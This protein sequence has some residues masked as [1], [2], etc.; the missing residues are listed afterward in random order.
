MERWMLMKLFI[1]YI[2]DPTTPYPPLIHGLQMVA[3]SLTHLTLFGCHGL[4][5]RDILETCPNLEYLTT[6]HRDPIMPL[7]TSSIYPKMK[8]LVL[9]QRL[10]RPLKHETVISIISRFPSLRVVEIKPMAESSVLP[11]LHKYCPHLLAVYFG[12][13]T[14][15][16]G[17]IA[18]VVYPN[19]K[20]IESVY[21][22]GPN[23]Y[24]QH[25]LIQFLHS[26]RDTLTLLQFNGDIEINDN[27]PWS[28]LNGH[29]LPPS[30]Q[31]PDYNSPSFPRLI[32]FHFTNLNPS[33]TSV[34]MVQ[35]ILSNAHNLSAI[36]IHD[37]YFRPEIAKA[38]IKLKHLRKVHIDVVSNEDDDGVHQFLKH[39]IALGDR[40]TLKYVMVE[41]SHID[42][43]AKPWI[44]LLSRL[45]RLKNLELLAQAISENCIPFMA[46]IGQGCPVLE[47]LTLGVDGADLADGLLVPLRNHPNIKWLRIGAADSLSVEDLV[48]LCTFRDLT[49]L[50][51][52]FNAADDVL[53]MLNK[54]IPNVEIDP[55][56]DDDE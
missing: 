55:Y 22:K 4:Q 6:R 3:D 15:H 51:L 8:H 34:P 31:P 53:E 1:Y 35:W 44:P 52:S 41:T 37:I 21:L 14:Y 18:D 11:L 24:K 7:S 54:H 2:G 30:D 39:H 42:I 46:E 33:T 56:D 45:P 29:V 47:N 49:K 20:G 43:S 9:Y 27:A 38:M 50:I 23:S 12:N 26:E 48:A 10:K 5:L 16:F 13:P 25:D 36:H 28:L 19:R 32:D 17:C 40:S